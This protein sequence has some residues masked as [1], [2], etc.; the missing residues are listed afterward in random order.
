SKE[1][2]RER[3]STCMSLICVCVLPGLDFPDC[4][5]A[6]HLY[7][8]EKAGITSGILVQKHGSHYRPVA[9][10]SLRLPPVVQGDA[11]LFSSPVV[12]DITSRRY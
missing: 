7:V 4:K 8:H 6:S 1:R 12:M 3:E 10:Y 9:S 11:S 5:S 2:E